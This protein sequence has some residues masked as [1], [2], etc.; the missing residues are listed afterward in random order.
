M[1]PMNSSD[2][3]CF[4]TNNYLTQSILTFNNCS[5]NLSHSGLSLIYFLLMR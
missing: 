1:T 2:I 3:Y 5:K 4:Y